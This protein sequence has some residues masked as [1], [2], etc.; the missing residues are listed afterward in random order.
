MSNNHD[1]IIVPEPQSFGLTSS[2]GTT[3]LTGSDVTI[4]CTIEWAP[5]VMES[6]LSLLMV[7]AQLF[8]VRNEVTRNLS[9]TSP[10]I[11]GTTFTYTTVVN[12]FSLNDS[13]NY[14]C[15][16]SIRPSSIYLYGELELSHKI[17]ITTGDC[18]KMTLL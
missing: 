9:L 11:S 6:E 16:A 2:A 3:V 18:D 17:S 4:H 5:T 13:G 1:I 7:D 8:M 14:S 15:V 10:G 12:S